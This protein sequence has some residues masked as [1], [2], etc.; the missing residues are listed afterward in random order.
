MKSDTN[1]RMPILAISQMNLTRDQVETVEKRFTAHVVDSRTS[2]DAVLGPRPKANNVQHV[3]SKPYKK[4][5]KKGSKK[6][7]SH[8][9]PKPKK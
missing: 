3:P 5:S 8:P 7:A 4:G 9:K 1:Q 6:G 2:L